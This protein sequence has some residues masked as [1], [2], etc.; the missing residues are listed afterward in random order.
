MG[1][2]R[3]TLPGLTKCGGTTLHHHLQL[4]RDGEVLFLSSAALDA[5]EALAGTAILPTF[6]AVGSSS[7]GT[8]L[9]ANTGNGNIN[10]M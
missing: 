10:F 3:W 7:V 5:Q 1:F 2:Q 6:C 8:P 9:H 4:S